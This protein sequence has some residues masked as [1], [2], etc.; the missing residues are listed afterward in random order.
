M[1]LTI[2]HGLTCKQGGLVGLRHD[3][4]TTESGELVGLALTFSRVSYEPE[5]FSGK[6]VVA[7]QRCEGEAAG[8]QFTGR[9]GANGPVKKKAMDNGGDLQVLSAPDDRAI[10]GCPVDLHAIAALADRC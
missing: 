8:P 5:I 4:V 2:E 7:G 6:G 1:P 10:A 3:D 9:S